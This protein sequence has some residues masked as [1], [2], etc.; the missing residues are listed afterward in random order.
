MGQVVGNALKLN[1]WGQ[2]V[3]IA[4]EDDV[5]MGGGAYVVHTSMVLHLLHVYLARGMQECVCTEHVCTYGP[6]A[7]AE[8][9][10]GSSKTQA[11]EV[12]AKVRR[13]SK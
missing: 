1:V 4:H 2:L 11:R 6:S 8:L 13:V 12:Y 9:S 10:S 7:R 5:R 3:G